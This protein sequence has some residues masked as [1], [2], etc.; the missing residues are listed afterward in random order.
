[1]MQQPQLTMAHGFCPQIYSQQLL[2]KLGIKKKK[3]PLNHTLPSIHSIVKHQLDWIQ[4]FCW[5]KQGSKEPLQF[6]SWQPTHLWRHTNDPPLLIPPRTLT[7]HPPWI[8]SN[9]VPSCSSQLWPSYVVPCSLMS[10]PSRFTQEIGIHVNWSEL[11]LYLDIVQLVAVW[12]RN[13]YHQPA[14]T[15]YLTLGWTIETIG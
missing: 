13:I 15:H 8:N 7:C 4:T 14:M 3:E 5:G 6:N 2:S 12:V 10:C 9:W 1:M 11:H